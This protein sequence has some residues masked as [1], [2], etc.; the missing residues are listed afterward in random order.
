MRCYQVQC[1]F[2][3]DLECTRDADIRITEWGTCDKFMQTVFPADMLEKEKKWQRFTYKKIAEMSAEALAQAKDALEKKYP[4]EEATA[5]E[6]EKRF[7][8]LREQG[9]A[10]AE[11]AEGREKGSRPDL[12][13]LRSSEEP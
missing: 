10:L 13:I 7:L 5:E 9:M 12:C 3:K 4:L 1:V 8:V 2:Q 11:K 6:W